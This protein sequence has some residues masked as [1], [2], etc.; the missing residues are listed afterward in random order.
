MPIEKVFELYD[1]MKKSNALDDLESEMFVDFH[2]NNFLNVFFIFAPVTNHH[3][4]IE[5]LKNNINVRSVFLTDRE[6][7]VYTSFIT[8]LD[9]DCFIDSLEEL[10]V[11]EIED[12]FIKEIVI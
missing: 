4:I 7:I 10:G 12:Y 8:L 6:F 11:L 1:D 5:Y 3:K 2:S 9:Y